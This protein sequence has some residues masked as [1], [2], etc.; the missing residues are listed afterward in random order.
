MSPFL[1]KGELLSGKKEIDILFNTGR[2]F[3]IYPFR[4]IYEIQRKPGA[5]GT[6]VLFSVPKKRFSKAVHRN[7]L[8]R[9]MRE[10]DRL[11]K[12]LLTDATSSSDI[13]LSLA[14]VYTGNELK[15]FSEIEHKIILSLNR[16]V[17]EYEKLVT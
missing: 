12:N 7:S 15:E 9:K 10:A 3:S 6:V 5:N 16:L 8:K 2:S 11:N 1:K 17:K 4:V 13:H 14:F